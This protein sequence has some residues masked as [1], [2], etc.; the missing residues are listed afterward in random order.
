MLTLSGAPAISDFRLAKLLASLRDSVGH[1][2]RLDSRY[3][4]F[5]DVDRDL[6]ADER[7]VLESLLRYGPSARDGQ[8]RGELLLVVPRSGTVSPWSSKATDI[9][10]VCGLGAVRR[11]ERGV[12]YY[13]KGAR[14]LTEAEWSMAAGPLHDRMT[15]QV[16]RDPAEAAALFHHAA[17]K[18][19]ATVPALAEGR[20]ALATANRNLGLALSDDEIDY[21][22]DAF[23]ALGRDPTD[24]ELMMFAQA[25]SE[26]CRHK[27]FN[28]EWIVDGVPSEK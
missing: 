20:A 25:N 12:A 18:P 28:A 27:I 7:R 24:V 22:L 19:L 5:V 9:A 16:L 6:T 3:V 21:L 26:H 17:P 23:H 15:E 10:H 8:P 11:I 2:A 13:L 14:A 4:H 1:L